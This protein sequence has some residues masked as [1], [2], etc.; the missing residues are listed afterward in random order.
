MYCTNCGVRVGDVNFCFRCGAEVHRERERG[1]WDDERSPGS[2]DRR[3]RSDAR[4]RWDRYDERDRRDRQDERDERGQREPGW[5]GMGRARRKAE[6]YIR[7][8]QRMQQL[9]STALNKA[10]SSRGDS[11]VFNEIWEHLQVAARLVQA[12]LRGEYTGLSGKNLTLIVAALIY[13]ISPVDIIPDFLPIAGM[14]D[15]VT[16]LTF[17]LRS[18]KGELEAFKEWER[19]RGRNID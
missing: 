15:D 18:L 4:E 1:S 17:A 3:D 14:L 10:G 12:S 16:V 5:G 13:Y 6:E 19:S 8:P 2:D 7:D 11:K 9:F